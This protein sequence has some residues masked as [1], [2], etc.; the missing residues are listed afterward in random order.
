MYYSISSRIE[1]K[2]SRKYDR[3]DY[4]RALI[5]KSQRY[6]SKQTI[7]SDYK[8][9][10]LSDS[11]EEPSRLTPMSNALGVN[12]FKTSKLPDI[13]PKI[14]KFKSECKYGTR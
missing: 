6:K 8:M 13:V 1:K 5:E 2:L 11:M 10:V 4:F 14:R 12:R 7:T 9:L 3:V